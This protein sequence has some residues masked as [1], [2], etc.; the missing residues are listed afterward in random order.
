MIRRTLM[1]M[2]DRFHLQLE[3]VST[4]YHQH[5]IFDAKK[6]STVLQILQVHLCIK[7]GQTYNDVLSHKWV[8]SEFRKVF[9]DLKEFVS[10]K[11]SASF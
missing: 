1:K 2:L 5:T 11:E 7:F 8:F 3:V 4:V 9:G 10:Y 6:V